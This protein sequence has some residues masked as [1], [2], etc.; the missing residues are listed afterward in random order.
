MWSCGRRRA[1][2]GRWD[3]PTKDT[4]SEHST[5]SSESDDGSDW[6][7]D[8]DAAM[9]F[10]RRLRAQHF[11]PSTIF[12]AFDPQGTG[13]IS[14]ED[15]KDS[16]ARLDASSGSR[17]SRGSRDGST[18]VRSAEEFAAQCV[19][20]GNI[21]GC[22]GV[23]ADDER[24][25]V[26]RYEKHTG[27]P[28]LC[29]VIRYR[30]PTEETPHNNWALLAF[31][32]AASARELVGPDG[33]RCV[34]PP[35]YMANISP[36]EHVVALINAEKALASDGAFGSIFRKLRERS[37]GLSA[38]RTASDSG[39]GG[40]GNGSL[41][42]MGEQLVRVLSQ[43]GEIITRHDFHEKV[44]GTVRNRPG[45][46]QRV[47]QVGKADTP[48]RLA[49]GGS[50]S[51]SG[52]VDIDTNGIR[53]SSRSPDRSG[54]RDSSK[55]K[56]RLRTT[57]RTQLGRELQAERRLRQ[58][59]LLQNMKAKRQQREDAVREAQRANEQRLA[60]LAQ[61]ALAGRH[62]PRD[63][64]PRDV[65]DDTTSS[66]DDED[67]DAALAAK[68]L[69]PGGANAPPSSPKPISRRSSGTNISNT[70]SAAANRE[71]GAHLSPT[72]SRLEAEVA[73]S[74]AVKAA[75]ESHAARL[76][77]NHEKAGHSDVEVVVGRGHLLGASIDK[78]VAEL[79]EVDV[80]S[81]IGV[82]D[83]LKLAVRAQTKAPVV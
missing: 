31:G 71:P 43:D 4:S 8:G 75:K 35:P 80:L 50:S 73:A 13:V 12:T 22:T 41:L 34:G 76:I 72:A 62:S 42:S 46:L 78:I 60:E 39:G 5:E 45:L 52:S 51:G 33:R 54:R 66:D 44:V 20:V 67:E 49:G 9:Q 61:D 53:R 23:A 65:D 68:Y 10:A 48:R 28:V 58:R 7:E 2:G 1:V 57:P 24:A 77:I 17:G 18:S 30:T 29:A 82:D 55:S 27:A 63:L 56:S 37:M 70:Q 19:H 59:E 79:Q 64:P 40:V 3:H 81:S 21:G 14:V 15:F 25:L 16:L 69:N 26:R 36:T 47:R 38:K 6:E 32:T 74:E 11:D 83:L